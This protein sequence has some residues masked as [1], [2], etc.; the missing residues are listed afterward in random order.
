MTAWIVS[1]WNDTRLTWSPED[2]D[3]LAEMRVPASQIWI[4]DITVLNAAEPTTSM[5]PTWNPDPV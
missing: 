1:A 5:Y 2:H 4:P 3:G